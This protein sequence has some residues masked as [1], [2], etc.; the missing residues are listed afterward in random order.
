MQSMVV[1]TRA[2]TLSIRPLRNADTATIQAVFDQLGDES[3]RL[4]FGNATPVLAP[5]EL[6]ELSRVDGRHHVLVGMI[7][8]M[9][10]GIARL[11][12]DAEKRHLAEVAYAVA[13]AWQGHGIGTALMRSLVTD[14]AAAGI[15]HVRADIRL[16]NRASLSLLKKA[17]NIVSRRVVGGEIAV[18]ALTT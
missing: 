16:E 6:R 11:V 2:G 12:R 9:P 4:R 18:V 7:E 13:D 15:T 14:A 10:V 17:T 3:R 5:R 8:G 1:R